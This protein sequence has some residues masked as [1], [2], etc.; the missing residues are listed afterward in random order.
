MMKIYRVQIKFN[1]FIYENVHVI[2]DLSTK[3]I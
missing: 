2:T 1:Q 3:R